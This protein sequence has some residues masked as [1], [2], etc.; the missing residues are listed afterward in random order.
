MKEY[1]DKTDSGKTDRVPGRTYNSRNYPIKRQESANML[2]NLGKDKNF[3]IE[4][5][6]QTPYTKWFDYD[7]IKIVSP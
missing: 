6:P 1:F 5:I 3:S 7:I 4:Q 2:Y